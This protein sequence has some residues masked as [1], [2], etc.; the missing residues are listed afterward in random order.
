MIRVHV[1]QARKLFLAGGDV[2]IC[3]CNLCPRDH[4]G[5]EAWINLDQV[6]GKLPPHEAWKQVRKYFRLRKCNPITGKQ[7]SYYIEGEL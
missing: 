6:E 1:Q 4:F 3:P 7:L 5:A 2:A